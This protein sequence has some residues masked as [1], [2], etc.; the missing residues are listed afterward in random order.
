MIIIII[1]IYYDDDDD[2][3]FRLSLLLHKAVKCQNTF[4]Q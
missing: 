4:L 1:I 3:T 2:E